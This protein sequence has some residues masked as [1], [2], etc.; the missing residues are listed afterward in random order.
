MIKEKSIAV[1]LILTILT[2]GLFGIVWFI[3]LTDDVA[4]ASDDHQLS[5]GMALLLTILTCGL[6]SIYW[7]YVMGKR[8]CDAKEK[9]GLRGTDNSVLY[10]V[11]C[12]L[13]LN[14]VNYCLIQSELN[15]IA[16][17]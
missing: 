9:A 7:A 12:I 1:Y 6:Y 14:I 8:V 3:T 16:N 13:S 10:L 11:L 4:Y 17:N 15:E 5:G 2:C